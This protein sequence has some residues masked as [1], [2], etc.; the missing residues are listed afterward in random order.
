MREGLVVSILRLVQLH[1]RDILR[2]SHYGGELTK[3]VNLSVMIE[4]LK[5]S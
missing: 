5:Q 3:E 4:L 1:C 2:I